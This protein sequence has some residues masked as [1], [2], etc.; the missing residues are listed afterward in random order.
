MKITP[1][2]F[3]DAIEPSLPFWVERLGFTKTVEVPDGDRLGFAMLINGPGEIMLQTRASL[4]KDLPALLDLARPSGC[5]FIEVEDF[6]DLL[7]RVEGCEVVVPV[8]D[9]FYGMREIVVREPGGH[10]LCFA[11]RI[12]T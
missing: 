11:A 5:L 10:S 7:R 9:T 12:Q 2:L 4:E 3:V 1:V 6:T 8:R